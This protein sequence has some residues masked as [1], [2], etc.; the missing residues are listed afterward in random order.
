MTEYPIGSRE[1]IG[2][3]EEDGGYKTLTSNTMADD[4][5]I[6]GYNTVITPNMSLAWSEILNSGADT[7]EIKT[8]VKGNKI[9][10]FTLTFVPYNWTFLKYCT[11]PT[12]TNVDH[13]TYNSHTWSIANSIKSFTLEWA[14]RMETDNAITLTGCT[15]KDFKIKFSRGT[16][17]TDGLVTVEANCV[18]SDYSS[19]SSLTTLT[20][21]TAT[22]LRFF[23]TKLTYNSSEVVEVN[24]GEIRFN[25]GITEDDSRYCNDTYADTLAEPIPTVKRYGVTMNI[26]ASDSTYFDAWDNG[27][28]LSGTNKIRFYKSTHDWLEI[29]LTNA[30]V[31]VAPVPSTNLTGLNKIDIVMVPTTMAVTGEDG[32]TY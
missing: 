28:V 16:G 29:A 1:Q 5:E 27:D 20:P 14:N 3:V 25:N 18:A 21:P 17:P 11:H 26:N 8:M 31:G 4:G 23:D 2:W 10:N 22:P 32:N 7:P 15:I 19:S 30:R 6:V 9:I 13:T 12:V 24:S